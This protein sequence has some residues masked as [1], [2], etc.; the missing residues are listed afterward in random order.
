MAIITCN[1]LKDAPYQLI[2]SSTMFTNLIYEIDDRNKK[3]N[4]TIPDDESSV[5]RLAI[6]DSSGKLHVLCNGVETSE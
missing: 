3:F 6:E 2:L 5:R 1:D 4:V